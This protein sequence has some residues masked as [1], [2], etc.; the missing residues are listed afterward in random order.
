L[1]GFKFETD[2]ISNKP[3]PINT[4]RS[5]SEARTETTNLLNENKV[6]TN[7]EEKLGE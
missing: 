3:Q 7:K 2:K 5:S 4:D 1:T 6:D